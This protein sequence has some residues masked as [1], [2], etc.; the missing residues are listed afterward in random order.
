MG[1]PLIS[2]LLPVRDAA[3]HLDEALASLAG[4]TFSD[5]EVIAVDDGSLDA[6]LDILRKWAVRES[7]VQVIATPYGGIVSALETA[8]RVARGGYLARMDADDVA[9]PHR[10]ARQL[11]AIQGDRSLVAV[12]CGVAYF[13]RSSVGSGA[14]RYERW[15]NSLT[16]SLEIERDLFVEC[17]LAHPA[18]LLRADAVD[19]AGGY[20]DPGWPEDYD[21]IL[22]LWERGG[23][24][25]NVPE[26]LLQWRERPGRLSRTSPAYS[27]DAFR[28]CKV[29]Y[30]ER[31]LLPGRDG[32]VVWGAG[33][34]GKGFARALQAVGVPLRA[35]V[36]L[37]PRKIGKTIHG[38]PVVPPERID[39]FR[40]AF[41]VAAVGQAGAR[42]EI[43]SALHE[44]GWREMEDFVA[45]A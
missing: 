35:F 19:A 12:G 13:P 21:L 42:G 1:R 44:A 8:R 27:A 29:H 9:H 41:C 33:P 10:L 7:R 23:R 14:R 32:T 15:I 43:R 18:L 4:Q 45:V 6:S 39:H 30:L 20:R 31:N 28:R 40:G 34:T 24:F 36:E 16:T 3:K 2:V 11:A 17:P 38:A 25:A 22:R 37:D 26:V 5:F